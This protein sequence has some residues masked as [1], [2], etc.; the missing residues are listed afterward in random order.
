[1]QVLTLPSKSKSKRCT[2]NTHPQPH[3]THIGDYFTFTRCMHHHRRQPSCASPQSS[4]A[5]QPTRPAGDVRG[6]PA[7]YGAVSV[8]SA[9]GAG[10]MLLAATAG[11]SRRSTPRAH[12][13]PQH[14]TT[15]P[16]SKSSST[17]PRSSSQDPRAPKSSPLSSCCSSM[18]TGPRRSAAHKPSSDHSAS[19]S[20]FAP[21]VPHTTHTMLLAFAAA[22]ACFVASTSRARSALA[23]ASACAS[24]CAVAGDIIPLVVH[25]KA[26]LP[27]LPFG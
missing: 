14:S 22:R 10:A 9:P 11:A 27:I 7:D 25:A 19:F 12:F 2:P 8:T 26:F 13:T 6:P 20:S 21:P 23:C 15:S 4:H 1:M 3:A 18:R 24:A 5:R 16:R 17:P